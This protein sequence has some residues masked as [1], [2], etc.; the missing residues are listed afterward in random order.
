MMLSARLLLAATALCCFATTFAISMDGFATGH[1]CRCL[2]TTSEV[3]PT[4]LFRRIEIL[5]PGPHCGNI[6]ILVTLKSNNVVCVSPDEKWI[7][8]LIARISR[9]RQQKKPE[10]FSAD[11]HVLK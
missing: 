9:N 2:T 10:V 11:Q 4:R 5:A 1:K 3:I 8:E 6:E 7:I